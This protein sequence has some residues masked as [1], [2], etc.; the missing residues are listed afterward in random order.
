VDAA[1]PLLGCGEQPLDIRG[2]RDVGL[3]GESSATGPLD[4]CR[5]LAC[6]IL[7]AQI[8][9]DDVRTRSGEEDR[10]LPAQ[11]TTAAGNERGSPR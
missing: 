1:E 9:N 6:R 4:S 2:P 10:N 11:A 5:S 7:V 3:D 8:V